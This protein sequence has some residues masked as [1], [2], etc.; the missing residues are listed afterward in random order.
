[1]F[2]ATANQDEVRLSGTMVEGVHAGWTGA[3]GGMGVPKDDCVVD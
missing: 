3:E 2:D 1:M